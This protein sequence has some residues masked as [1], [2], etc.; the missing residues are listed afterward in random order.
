[1]KKVYYVAQITDATLN[2]AGSGV[3]KKVLDQISYFNS[4]PDIKCEYVPLDQTHLIRLVSC[5][6]KG[7]FLKDVHK[8]QYADFI[9][10]RHFFPISKSLI[11]LFNNIKKNNPNCKILYEI[12]T[13][14]YDMEIKTFKEKIA[15][16]F[17]KK[18]RKELK[19]VV[20]KII[21]LSDDDMIY[22]IS[23]LHMTNGIDTTRIPIAKCD[24]KQK[25]TISLIAVA[26]FNFWHGYDRLI[27]GLHNYYETKTFEEKKVSL[28]L[29]GKNG[30]RYQ[31][32]ID[33][34]KLNPFVYVCGELYGDDL[35]KKFNV[36]DIAV[37]SLGGHR[38]GIVKKSSELKSREY[39]ARGLPIVTS[40]DIDIISHDC[41][42]V[43]KV[44]VDDSPIDIR[45]IIDFYEKNYT[46]S[47]HDYIRKFAEERCSVSFGLNNVLKFIRV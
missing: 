1:M 12:P 39:L 43:L 45:K 31:R 33:K 46:K 18:Y 22:G 2:N 30:E 23:T 5:F 7:M 9:Y 37:C 3:S 17:D 6:V 27:E 34:Y 40:V 10:V 36:S 15:L 8:F 28:N 4:L 14:P 47:K 11:Y 16:F 35:D 25:D 21:T 20:D 19:N 32:L 44:P 41:D 42:F 38:K 26:Q 13:Y 24:F 29:I